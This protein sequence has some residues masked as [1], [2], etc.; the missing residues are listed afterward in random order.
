L[1]ILSHLDHKRTFLLNVG[2]KEYRK[3]YPGVFQNFEKDIYNVLISNQHLVSKYKH[4][5]LV[6]PEGTQTKEITAGFNKFSKKITI[7]TA[8]KSSI[9]AAAIAK[10][11]AFIV[12]DDKHLVDLVALAKANKW[13]LGKDIGVL[14]YN[15]TILKS[16][17]GDGITTFTTDFEAMGKGIAEI[18]VTGRRDVIENP[19]KLIDRHSF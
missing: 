16:A 3:E 9:N 18:A 14:S 11:D 4:L 6:F 5:T 13:Q 8:V 19:F 12:T 17:I 2:Y 7:T 15:E 1:N 10:G